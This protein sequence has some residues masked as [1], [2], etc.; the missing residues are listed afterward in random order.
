M[1]FTEGVKVLKLVRERKGGVIPI[2]FCAHFICICI[3]LGLGV[4]QYERTIAVS[5]CTWNNT[6]IIYKFVLRVTEQ[7]LRI[8]TY[9]SKVY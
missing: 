5:T 8:F 2:E 3:D 1:A 9:V 4:G 6:C 7:V